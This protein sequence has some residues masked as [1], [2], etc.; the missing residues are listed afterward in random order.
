MMQ[1]PGN[2]LVNASSGR[3][4]EHSGGALDNLVID[5]VSNFCG[6]DID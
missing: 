5:R 2:S 6:E 1:H 4:A 3:K